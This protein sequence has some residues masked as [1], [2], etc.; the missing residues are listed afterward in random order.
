M[1]S[2]GAATAEAADSV[3]RAAIQALKSGRRPRAQ[4][5]A[6][7]LL[8]GSLGLSLADARPRRVAVTARREVMWNSMVISVF[9]GGVFD[10]KFVVSRVLGMAGEEELERALSEG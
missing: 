10:G 4:N 1:V 9:A 8:L 7:Q 5:G 6:P 3:A 2:I